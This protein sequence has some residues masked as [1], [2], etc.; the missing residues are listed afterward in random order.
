MPS[1]GAPQKYW[2]CSVLGQSNLKQP[3]PT[4]NYLMSN[5]RPRRGAW[6]TCPRVHCSGQ[7]V[8]VC[9]VLP[10][11]SCSA[12]AKIFT[13]VPADLRSATTPSA[14]SFQTYLCRCISHIKTQEQSSPRS[15]CADIL[16]CVITIREKGIF[17]SCPCSLND[18]CAGQGPGSLLMRGILVPFSF[19]MSTHI[20]RRK[21]N[22]INTFCTWCLFRY[23]CARASAMPMLA[24]SVGQTE[25]TLRHRS[26]GPSSGC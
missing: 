3:C 17:E 21:I 10:R 7:E 6:G 14:F 25:R 22:P 24:S 20:L 23:S 15:V 2:L 26:A 1:Y 4:A 16:L 18:D 12:Q 13:T 9:R 8:L 11:A 19:N 5:S